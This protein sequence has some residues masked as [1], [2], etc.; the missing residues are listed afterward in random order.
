MDF[1]DV[2]GQKSIGIE[3]VHVSTPKSRISMDVN[4]SNGNV[5]AFGERVFV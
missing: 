1:A 3:F 4:D 5:G 2:I